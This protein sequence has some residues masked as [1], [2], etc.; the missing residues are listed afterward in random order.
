M[1]KGALDY[2]QRGLMEPEGISAA[3][4]EY[5]EE[6]DPLGAFVR[7]ACMVTG[8]DGDR[9]SPLELF[10]AYSRFARREGLSE[11]KQAT[12]TKRFPDQTRK[13]WKGEDGLMHSFRKGK[14]SVTVYYGIRIRDEF[15]EQVGAAAGY[16][17]DG[18]LPEPF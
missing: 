10:N 16:H 15:R 2:L 4:R 5:R 1:V 7:G 17:D 3:T 8:S 12:F 14:S 6:N 18:P 13:N 11:F 9:E